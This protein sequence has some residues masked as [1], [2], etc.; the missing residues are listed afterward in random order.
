MSRLD[1]LIFDF[2]TGSRNPH[3]TQPTQLAAIALDGR[4]LKLKGTFNS[5]IRPILDDA[6]AIE[7]GLDPVEEEALIKTKKTREALALAPDLKTVWEKFVPFVNKYNW[8][9]TPF[10]APIPAGYNIIGFD[11]VIA[12]RMCKQ[13]GPWDDK[14]DRPTLFSKIWKVDLMDNMFMW[15]EGDP[16]IK[17]INMDALRKMFG[18][19]SE[20]AHNALQDVKDT[21]N[22]IIKMMK[23]HRA[24]YRNLEFDKAFADGLPCS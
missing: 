15:T 1:I 9:G 17:S 23:T 16:N 20:G 4:N 7:L 11:L 18:M 21:A 8:K 24:V 3:K 6:K 14:E 22:I 10:F 5:E 19:S 12:N 13:F 2:E